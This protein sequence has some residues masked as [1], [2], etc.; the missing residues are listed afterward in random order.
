[1]KRG[2]IIG[3][4]RREMDWAWNNN[5][6]L[7]MYLNIAVISFAM[8]PIMWITELFGYPRPPPNALPCSTWWFCLFVALGICYIMFK[9]KD[10]EA[11][12]VKTLEQENA[13]L[14]YEAQKR[15]EEGK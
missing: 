11:K 2:Q 7:Y 3:W 6:M 4:L 12:R 13:K 1:M 5:K 10:L 9:N 8:W 14:R 15:K